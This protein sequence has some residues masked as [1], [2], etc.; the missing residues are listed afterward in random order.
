MDYLSFV[1]E[2]TRP[3]AQEINLRARKMEKQ[4]ARM[5]AELSAGV[6]KTEKKPR[7]SFLKA[8]LAAFLVVFGAPRHF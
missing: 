3:G 2:T 5:R 8:L 4:Q 6:A 1:S 7:R